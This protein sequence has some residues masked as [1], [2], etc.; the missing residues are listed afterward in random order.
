MLDILNTV[1]TIKNKTSRKSNSIFFLRKYGSAIN[2]LP[3]RS[4]LYA[5]GL[6][7]DSTIG[8]KKSNI[9]PEIVEE[10]VSRFFNI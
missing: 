3:R 2:K 10:S 6:L 5:R 9:R 1:S 4:K 7:N 8:R